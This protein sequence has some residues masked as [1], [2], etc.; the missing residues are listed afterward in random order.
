MPATALTPP[1][2]VAA[3]LK[4]AVLYLRVS[5]FKQIRPD[6]AEGL[7]IPEQ[8]LACQQRAAAIGAEV[9]LE[10]VE[11]A[12]AKT[13]KDRPALQRML[14]DLKLRGDIDYVI[15]WKIDRFAR[16]RYDEA[17]IGQQL[18]DLGVEFVSV[19]ENIDNSPSGRFLR[20]V[21]ASHAE[22]DNA[23]RAER[24]RLSLTRKA[25]MGGT[26]YLPPPG[27]RLK[28]TTVEGRQLSV[29]EADP[30]QAALMT[31]AFR[32]YASGDV[33]LVGLADEMH[34]LGLRTATG[35]KLKANQLHRQLRNPYYLGKVP[36]RGEVYDG[37]KHPALID[38]ATFDRVQQIMRAHATAGEKRRTHNHYLKG[39]IFC[40]HCGGRMV[41]NLAAGNGGK[42]AYFFCVGRRTG[43]PSKHLPVDR[44][45]A[46]V[47]EH[48]A[49][50][51]LTP[52]AVARVRNAVRRYGDALRDQH[53]A[54]TQRYQRRLAV[55]QQKR[56]K[57]FDAYAAEAMSLEQFKRKQKQLD[58]EEADARQ[59]QAV[60]IH[61]FE[62]IERIALLALK[63]AENAT[64]TYRQAEDLERRLMNQAIYDKLLI[65]ED[66]IESAVLAQPF[67][68][69]YDQDFIAGLEQ[70]AS[71]LRAARTNNRGRLS[72]GRGWNETKMARPTGFEPVT[73]ASGGRRSIQL[74]Y[75]RVR[76]EGYKAATG[77]WRR[78][79]RWWR[80]R[81]SV[82]RMPS[83]EI[84]SVIFDVPAT[85][86]QK[87]NGTSSMRAPARWASCVVSTWNA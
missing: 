54:Q 73:S 46:A 25:Q 62:N 66:G 32:R 16:K 6:N 77:P 39:T 24:A 19:S 47:T 30:E 71:K 59:L 14:G 40:G 8:R 64:D 15:V 41:F 20:G 44:V 23:I 70:E 34:A 29:S 35:G 45:E 83:S 53:E 18:E 69:L 42:Y 61:V 43:C 72:S 13:A 68:E 85:R 11:R 1:S 75:G 84:R 3:P 22:Y 33:S 78:A 49:H 51:Q 52:T 65:T 58:T 56:D 10:Y 50:I 74:S 21:L 76:V 63:L 17:I 87:T 4:K 37:G 81:A 57:L 12:S 26:P 82:T 5:S 27:Y 7:S 60:A 80:R 31:V 38:Q 86:S 36:F 9:A 67:A 48:Y 28:R 55:I 2:A 79:G